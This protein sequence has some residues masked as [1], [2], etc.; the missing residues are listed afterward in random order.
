MKSS[1]ASSM[2]TIIENAA[3]GEK[4]QVV[5]GHINR[6]D[7]VGSTGLDSVNIRKRERTRECHGHAHC[8]SCHGAA[9]SDVPADGVPSV[10]FKR[11]DEVTGGPSLTKL[12][13]DVSL[14]ACGPSLRCKSLEPR[15]GN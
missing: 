3:I 8:P 9:R 6:L 7:P 11:E 1:G 5:G 4:R 15:I 10:A 14:S 13:D 12:Q 2:A